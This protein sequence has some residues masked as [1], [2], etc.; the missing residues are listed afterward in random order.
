[1]PP[2]TPTTMCLP[3]RPSSGAIAPV[4]ELLLDP[5]LRLGRALVAELAVGDLLEGDRERLGVLAE[6]V[7]LRRNEVPDPLAELRVVRVDLA[8][9]L[10][11]EDHERV[12]A[13]DLLYQRFDLWVG[14]GEV[15]FGCISAT[16]A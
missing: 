16:S 5:G 13:V 3:A 6:A 4:N 12:P 10:C 15:L 7:D 8:G 1:M 2:Q 11:R 14:Q 9:T